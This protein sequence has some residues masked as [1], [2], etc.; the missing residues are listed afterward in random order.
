MHR[1]AIILGFEECTKKKYY[2]ILGDWAEYDDSYLDFIEP[3]SVR[4][5]ISRQLTGENQVDK[6]VF[7]SAIR[8][9]V[10]FINITIDS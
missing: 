5:H 1:T 10:N 8:N 6:Q 9:N 2:I 7:I 4:E 3:E